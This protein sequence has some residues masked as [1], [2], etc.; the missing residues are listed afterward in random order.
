[1]GSTH[2]GSKFNQELDHRFWPMFPLARASQLGI[3]VF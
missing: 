1:M 3:P 2:V